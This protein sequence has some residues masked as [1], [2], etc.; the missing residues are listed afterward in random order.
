MFTDVKTVFTEKQLK[1]ILQNKGFELVVRVL[2]DRN[3]YY[4]HRLFRWSDPIQ[5]VFQQC[6][7]AYDVENNV[8]T[9]ANAAMFLNYSAG[10]I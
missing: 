7:F 6:V 5:T 2:A 3:L 4:A 9:F 1:K 10:K 8:E